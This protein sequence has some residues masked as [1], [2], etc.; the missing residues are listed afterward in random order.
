MNIRP[1]FRR[2][3]SLAVVLPGLLLVAL[4]M[5]ALA[6]SKDAAGKP[7][8]D[9]IGRMSIEELAE[10]LDDPAIVVLDARTGS[11]WE[12]EKHKIKG[13]V[14][15][16]PRQAGEWAKSLDKSKH[17]V[18]YCTCYDESTSLRVGL[19]LLENG[20]PHVYALVG[21]WDAWVDAGLPVEPR[22]AGATP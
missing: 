18:L 5:P 10:R 8:A 3:C 11:S 2:A 7:T 12:H 1:S 14:R 22:D 6:A 15:H 17:Y 4:A 19:R 9:M 16:E 20:V 13:A 21:G